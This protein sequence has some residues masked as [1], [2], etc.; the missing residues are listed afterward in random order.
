MDRMSTIIMKLERR[1][2]QKDAPTWCAKCQSVTT[3][4]PELLLE[5]PIV[6]HCW[7]G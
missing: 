1:E 3:L 7:M 4:P 6:I 2:Q 5:Q